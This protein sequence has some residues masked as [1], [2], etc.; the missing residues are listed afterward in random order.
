[1][2]SGMLW[3]DDDKQRPFEEKVKRAANYYREKYGTVPELCRVNPMM[4]H[5]KVK[6]GKIEVEPVKTVLPHHFWLGMKMPV[7]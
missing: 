6:V 2:N 3:L 4:V 5:E 1:M 7:V